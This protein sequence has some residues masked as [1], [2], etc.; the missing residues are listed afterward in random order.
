MSARDTGKSASMRTPLA[1]VR[2]LG[3]AHAGTSDF[4]RQ[5][6]TALAMALLIIPVAVVVLM[7]TGRDQAAAAQ[8][9]GS[10]IVAILLALFIVAGCLH[11]KIGVQVV[12]E[13]YVHGE[14]LKLLAIIANNFFSFAVG[15]AS[16]FAIL[17][18]SF[19]S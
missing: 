19:G 13:D 8:L 10:P 16:I 17:K 14:A 5:R 1:N 6:V 12:I 3:A 18:L 4:F 9:L 15:L 11:M 2:R 7:L